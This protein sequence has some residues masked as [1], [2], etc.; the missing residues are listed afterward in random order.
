MKSITDT[1][2]SVANTHSVDA[3]VCA[4]PPS[5]REQCQVHSDA[6][7]PGTNLTRDEARARAG[8][9]QP[10]QLRRRA[11][12]DRPRRRATF[13]H[14]TTCIVFAARAGASTFIDLV[15][16][17]VREVD[18]QR[19]ALDP[20]TVFDGAPDPAGRAR[21]GNELG[22]VADCVYSR[23][24]EGLHRF[25]DPVDKE[26]YLYTQFE[27]A[28]ARRMF[29]VLR[30]A[31]P[32]GDLHL[33]RDRTGST[34]GRLQRA[35]A[36]AATRRDGKRPVGVR[37]RPQRMSTYITALVAGPYHAV[38]GHTTTG[39]STRWRSTAAR[40]W[41]SSSTPTSSST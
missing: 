16:E 28:D 33:H 30:P 15:A 41:R 18:A 10:R 9:A 25:V 17:Q 2:P 7:M 35:D 6:D 26:V 1:R 8:V 39:R 20:A 12:P 13:R 4:T 29:A 5:M 36:G 23:T 34:G 31:G 37:R 19:P 3:P 27:I 21:R 24:G 14:V 40:R 22:V 11:G 32:Q 38:D